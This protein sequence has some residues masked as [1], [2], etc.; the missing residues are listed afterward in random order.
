MWQIFLKFQLVYTPE[1]GSKYAPHAM[2]D[3][4][5]LMSPS[6]YMQTKMWVIGTLP[7]Y[8]YILEDAFIIP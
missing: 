2:R 1:T 5:S 4:V 7:M 8:E 3:H 6:L